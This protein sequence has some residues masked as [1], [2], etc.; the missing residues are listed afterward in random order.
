MNIY[1]VYVKYFQGVE[2]KDI[3]CARLGFSFYAALFGVLWFAY[4][5]MWVFAV[6]SIAAQYILSLFGLEIISFFVWGFLAE[7]LLDFYL[8]RRGFVLADL[9][10]ADSEEMA[11]EIFVGVNEDAIYE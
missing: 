1:S 9:V 6:I 2:I 8:R 10:S 3:R 4:N 11:E 5:R 7:D